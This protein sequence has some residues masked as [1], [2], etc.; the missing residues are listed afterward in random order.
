[1]IPNGGVATLNQYSCLFQLFQAGKLTGTKV[2]QLKAKYTE[3]HETL[4][5]YSIIR[6][7][8]QNNCS[9]HL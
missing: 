6:G 4:K 1:M 7:M 2:A 9:R 3:L 8:S 5:R